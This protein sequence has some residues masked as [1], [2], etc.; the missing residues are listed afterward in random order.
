MPEDKPNC[1]ECNHR[2]TLVNNCHT[3]C[4][5]PEVVELTIDTPDITVLPNFYI[6]QMNPV[7][8]QIIMRGVEK[9]DIKGHP[10]GIK[11]GRF[12][13]PVQFDPTWLLNCSGFEQKESE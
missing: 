7:V 13:W 11:G 12:D 1:Y 2:G 9:L 8:F 10:T 5:H 3:R 4:L 6:M